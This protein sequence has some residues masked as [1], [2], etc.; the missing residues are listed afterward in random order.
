MTAKTPTAVNAAASTAADALD[1]LASAGTAAYDTIADFFAPPHMI[2]RRR[3]RRQLSLLSD[4]QLAELGLTRIQIETASDD[5]PMPGISSSAGAEA[6]DSIA[7]FF[8]PPH[9]IARRRRRRQLSLLTDEQLTELGLTRA[10]VESDA[11]LPSWDLAS[12]TPSRT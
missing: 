2:A 1:T 10:Q 12:A 8:A 9:M 6:L 11:D 5:D 7:D 3:R 4:E